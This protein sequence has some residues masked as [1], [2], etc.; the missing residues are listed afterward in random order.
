MPTQ[1]LCQTKG[2]GVKGDFVVQSFYLLSV[3]AQAAISAEIAFRMS[4]VNCYIY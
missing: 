4:I 2:G 3:K 1:F